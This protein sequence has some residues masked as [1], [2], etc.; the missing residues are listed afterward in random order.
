LRKVIFLLILLERE[1][2]EINNYYLK[3]KTMKKILIVPIILLSTNLMAG[4]FES[5]KEVDYEFTRQTVYR[6]IEGHQTEQKSTGGWLRNLPGAAYNTVTN[7]G[8]SVLG[9]L[10]STVSDIAED[11]E[12]TDENVKIEVVIRNPEEPHLADQ[13][14]PTQFF[15][16]PVK[17]PH[18]PIIVPK[19]AEQKR[20]SRLTY[21]CFGMLGIGLSIFLYRYYKKQGVRTR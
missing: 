8:A 9:V 17:I 14:K 11:T 16:D 10:T 13:N 6:D 18:E 2:R 5:A 4:D 19:L 15:P 3:E 20:K 12:T 21:A 7:F 1:L